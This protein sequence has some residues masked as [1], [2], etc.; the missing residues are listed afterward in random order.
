LCGEKQPGETLFDRYKRQHKCCPDCD[1]VLAADSLYC[2]NCASRYYQTTTKHPKEVIMKNKLLLSLLLVPSF[3]AGMIS[4]TVSAAESSAPVPLAPVGESKENPI[5]ISTMDQLITE[6]EKNVGAPTYYKLTEDVSHETDIE[7]TLFGSELMTDDDGYETVRTPVMAQC[8]VGTGKKFLELDGYDIHYK[9]NVNFNHSDNSYYAKSNSKYKYDSLTFFHLGDGCDLTVTNTTGDDAQVWYDGWMHNRTNF[10][11]GPNY[12]YTAVRDVF[13]VESGAE[14]SVSNTDIKAGRNR[15]I[16]MVHSFYLDKDDETNFIPS[17]TWDGYAYEQ[18]YGS[19]IVANGGKVTING[20]YIE[21]RGG[22][23]NQFNVTGVKEWDTDGVSNLFGDFIT[24][25][26]LE[27]CLSKRGTKA[28][29]QIAGEGST[30]I[31][32]D[33]EFWGCG[34]ADVIGINTLNGGSVKEYTLRINAG[35]FDTSKTDKERVPD[36]NAGT[37]NNGP[38]PLSAGNFSLWANCRCIRDTLRGDIGIPAVD[39]YGNNVFNTRMLHVY[40]DE[41]DAE[42]EC[43]KNADLDFSNK[44]DSDTI[45]VKPREEMSYSFSDTNIKQDYLDRNLFDLYAYSKGE[46]VADGF[47]LYHGP[48]ESPTFYFSAE[49]HYDMTD[50][51]NPYF[52]RAYLVICKWVLYEEDKNGNLLNSYERVSAPFHTEQKNGH[53]VYNF[54][55]PLSYFPRYSGVEFDE[56][57]KYY[58]VAYL[59]ERFDGIVHSYVTKSYTNGVFR[60]VK[61]GVY[62]GI[63]DYYYR[64]G[65]DIVYDTDY[66]GSF[67]TSGAEVTYSNAVYNSEPVLTFNDA[68]SKLKGSKIY[69]WQ[70]LENGEWIDYGNSRI[71][72]E[73]AVEVLLYHRDLTGKQVRMKITSYDGIYK[74]AL[75]SNVCTVQKD[76]N[77]LWPTIGVFDWYE[78][79]NNDGKYILK[80][81]SYNDALEWLIYPYDSDRDLSTL[82]W[83][84]AKA[85][86]VFDNLEIGVY[87]VYARF[88]ETTDYEAGT[89]IGYSK[90][91]AGNYVAPTGTNILYNEKPVNEIFVKLNETF[92]LT[93]GPVPDNATLNSTN[94]TRWIPDTENV[95]MLMVLNNGTPEFFDSEVRGRTI[96]FITTELGYITFNAVTPLADG[97][98]SIETITVR[99]VPENYVPY[100]VSVVNRGS[101][102]QEGGSFIP[103]LSLHARVEMLTQRRASKFEAEDLTVDSLRAQL[104]SDTIKKQLRDRLTWALVEP[105]PQIGRPPYTESTNKASINTKTGEITLKDAA[106]PGNVISFVGILDDPYLGRITIPGSI[107]VVAAPEEEVH[108]CD[109]EGFSV[110]ENDLEKHYRICTCGNK[111]TEAHE[112]TA[113]TIR[114]ATS[115][116]DALYGYICACGHSYEAELEGTARPHTHSLIYTYD[117]TQHWQICDGEDCPETDLATAKQDHSFVSK[118]TNDEGKELFV[119]STC[120]A[121]KLDSSIAVSIISQPKDAAAPIGSVAKVTLTAAGD[122]LT[123]KW[124]FK[125]KGATKFTYTDSFKSNTYSVSM[126]DA[127]DGRQIYCVVTDVYGNSVTSDTVTLHIA[128]SVV[129]Q[130]KSVVAASGATAKVTVKAAG[131]GLTYK[132]YFK[133]KDASTFKLTTSFTGN[134]YTAVMNDT[135]DGRQIYCVITD[136][137]GNSVKT[138]TVTLIMGNTVKIAA[139]PK[140]AVAASG[141]KASVK[142]NAT[143]DGLTYKWYFKNADA[144]KF[145][146]TTSFTGNTY[147][148]VMNDTRDGRQVYCV[149]TDK[150]GNSV[151]TDTVTLIMGNTVEIV[152]QPENAVAASGEKASVKVNATGD[153][154]TYKWFF[155]NKTMTNF[156]ESTSITSDTY[157]VNKMTSLRDGRQIYCVI[158]DKYGNSVKTDT[159]TLIMGNAVEIVAQPENAVAASGEKASVKVYA[160]GDGLTYK[161]FYKNKTMT[162]FVESTSI[163]SDTYTVNKMTSLRDGRQIYCVITDKYGNS[164]TTNTVILTQI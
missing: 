111:I 131:D 28:A 124:Y 42:H 6:M 116:S 121:I 57:N 34:G 141:K 45:I 71:S 137:Y 118:G 154:L 151:K 102:V 123:Y 127:R 159:V 146:L 83:S 129:T 46:C 49:S 27:N 106:N 149:I 73:L 89:E 132:W 66:C 163:T 97:S 15:K 58:M 32:N 25:H 54:K 145:K 95:D 5:L 117:L 35:T 51:D 135:R 138:D 68:F 125:N 30:V 115:E 44:S 87:F 22:Y 104:Q 122:G 39:G 70:V 85:E 72:P 119:C 84:K 147:T 162:N 96:S 130:P 4:V 78:D 108:T 142:V 158:T 41:E 150:Y 112:Y 64:Y 24:E 43:I 47:T 7:T 155:K 90:V 2:P 86:P 38:W 79:P 3:L 94:V 157:T 99:V 55:I 62:D 82:D 100:T 76:Q 144:A 23:R 12:I 128:A 37:V 92:E 156:V 13:R 101:E 52:D 75:Y 80:T 53:T 56:N 10:S 48:G 16:W 88:K 50:E 107:T 18:I 40:I 143:G 36:R 14:L 11:D 160:T 65:M 136:K 26:M 98:N 164:V 61:D 59:E 114:E 69:Q 17:L 19:A 139:Q 140:N 29:V 33:G 133:N 105:I 77:T 93:V 63:F 21:G 31:I 91:V 120:G 81:N 148:A 152:A 110:I 67:A 1:T 74:D 60:D 109:Y 126:N 8:V 20:G 9:N 103:Q 134:T 113:Y 153:G 161:W